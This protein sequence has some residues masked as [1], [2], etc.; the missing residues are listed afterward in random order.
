MPKAEGL[1]GTRVRGVST[2]AAP[3]GRS[4]GARPPATERNWGWSGEDG[5]WL[6]PGRQSGQVPARRREPA[7]A[8]AAPGCRHTWRHTTMSGGRSH[9]GRGAQRDCSATWPLAA[10]DR[11]RRG[12]AFPLHS[13]QWRRPERLG[14]RR[15]AGAVPP[16]GRLRPGSGFAG[17]GSAPVPRAPLATCRHTWRHTDEAKRRT[18]EEAGSRGR[19]PAGGARRLDALSSRMPKAEGLWGTRHR[20]VSASTAAPAPDG[21][22]AEAPGSLRRS[23]LGKQRGQGPVCRLAACGQVPALPA[24]DLPLPP[25]RFL[26]GAAGTPLKRK[27]GASPCRPLGHAGCV[28]GWSV[29]GTGAAM[30]GGTPTKRS[31]PGAERRHKRGSREPGDAG[32]QGQPTRRAV[33]PD[34]NGRRPLGNMTPG[35]QHGDG[36]AAMADEQR[37]ALSAT[38]RSG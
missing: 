13:H 36:G 18:S 29:W 1:W 11:H 10:R 25:L 24:A 33:D 5:G 21:W 15:G 27:P 37:S 12:G 22:T 26:Q 3:A 16:P 23:D 4:V 8:F 35:R 9:L 2:A 31:P 32:R 19:R 6:A 14:K 17:G 7:S 34:A 20:G 38:K 30:P 28:P